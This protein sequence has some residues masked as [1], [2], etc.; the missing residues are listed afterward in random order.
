MDLIFLSLLAGQTL[1][2]LGLIA[3]CERNGGKKT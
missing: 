2:L 1:L 3:L